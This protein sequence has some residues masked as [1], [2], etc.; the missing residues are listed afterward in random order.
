M[1]PRRLV[2]DDRRRLAVGLQH[3]AA[4]AP[5][6]RPERR[7]GVARV[8]DGD[9]DRVALLLEDLALLE[10][11][12][13]RLGRLQARL[14][15]V[16]HVVGGG[17]RRPST[18]APPS[19]PSWSAPTR[20]QTDTSRRTSCRASRRAAHVDELVLEEERIGVAQEDQ[21][22]AGL[23]LRLGRALGRQ[24]QSRDRVH[25]HRDARLLAER[26]RLPSQL[27]VRRPAR[28]GC[29]SGTSAPASGPGRGPIE[30]QHRPRHGCRGQK[31]STRGRWHEQP[32]SADR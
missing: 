22:V 5:Q 18:T 11:L 27:I 31:R 1:A 3:L 14:A 26:L 10:Q 21:V 12:V 16:R 9:A 25:P 13:P 32:P 6:D 28:N 23:R 30:R 4:E 24:L 19:S 17:E 7:V 29:C 8:A 20:R 2:G 15:E